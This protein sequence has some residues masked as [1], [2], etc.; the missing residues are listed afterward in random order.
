MFVCLKVHDLLSQN[1]V[2]NLNDAPSPKKSWLQI[3]VKLV[4]PFGYAKR[5]YVLQLPIPYCESLLLFTTTSHTSI[6]IFQTVHFSPLNFTRDNK[7][8]YELS[9]DTKISESLKKNLKQSAQLL[10]ILDPYSEG[11]VSI[12]IL[13]QESFPSCSLKT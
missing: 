2:C 6:N 13:S 10:F 8:K 9:S 1:G 3:S 4:K 12:P 11:Y 7:K 5:L